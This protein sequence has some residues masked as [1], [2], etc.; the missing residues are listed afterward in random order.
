[1]IWGMIWGAVIFGEKITWN[2]ILGAVI[3]MVGVYLMVCEDE[4]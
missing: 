1:V 3:I 4:E 2:M